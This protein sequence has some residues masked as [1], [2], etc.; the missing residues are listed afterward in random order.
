MTGAKT[1]R[2]E[3]G[4]DVVVL[5]NDGPPAAGMKHGPFMPDPK[6]EAQLGDQTVKRVIRGD[7]VVFSAGVEP[8]VD[9]CM[10]YAG[11]APEFYIIGDANI[12]NNDMWRRFEM[13][14]TAPSVGGDV[15][16]C[17]ATAYAA[18]MQL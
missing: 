1:I 5:V 10:E 12:H 9:V 8:C 14:Q 18:A 4:A 2:V 15:K 13:P 3:D 6:D 16:H 17:T 7:S 11:V